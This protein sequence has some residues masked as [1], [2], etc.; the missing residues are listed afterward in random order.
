MKALALSTLAVG[1]LALVS[2]AASARIVCNADGDCWHAAEVY[3]YPATAGIVIHEDAW[4]PEA[5]FRWREHEGRGYWHGGAWV[6]F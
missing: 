3:E 1:A 6:G 5:R 4:K 2:T